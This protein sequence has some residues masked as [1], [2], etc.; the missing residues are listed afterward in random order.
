M[1]STAKHFTDH[2]S[3]RNIPDGF[4]P[5]RAHQIINQLDATH[6][7]AE[8]NVL[9]TNGLPADWKWSWK[10]KVEAMPILPFNPL[11]C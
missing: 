6:R 8:W 2:Y 9:R 7:Q 5:G 4:R 3:N 10:C 11:L 1:I